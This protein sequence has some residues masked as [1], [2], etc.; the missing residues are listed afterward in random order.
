[1]KFGDFIKARRNELGWTQPEA[2]TRVEIE[3]SYLSKLENGHS[4]PSDDVFA[5]LCR[6]YEI[7]IPQLY[8][9]LDSAG[10]ESLMVIE[11]IR[12]IAAVKHSSTRSEAARFRL[13]GVIAFGLGGMLLG[14][15]Q[16]APFEE[17][18]YIYQAGEF[19]TSAAEQRSQLDY[20]GPVFVEN[21]GGEEKTW[22]LIGGETIARNSWARWL[23][24]PG[25]GLLFGGAAS[26]ANGWR[27]R[28]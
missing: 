16:V 9:R 21:P 24:V 13:L 14:L 25:L 2:A 7:E 15:A 6:V 28:Q 10:L 18:R 26:F 19:G 8:Q 20:R 5:R 22:Q 17:N 23:M 3:Q 4:I 27:R 12:T 11:Q 1:M